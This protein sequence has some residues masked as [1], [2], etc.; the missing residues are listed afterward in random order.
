MFC[1]I[2]ELMT[3]LLFF[4]F[5]VF[6]FL[7]FCLFVF[8][9]FLFYIIDRFRNTCDN[10]FTSFHTTIVIPCDKMSGKGDEFSAMKGFSSYD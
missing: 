4:S 7:F 1:N 9:F 5:F 6:C 3:P 2:D 10:S 8:F